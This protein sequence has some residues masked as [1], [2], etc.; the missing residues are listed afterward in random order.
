[1]R[2]K[3][4][5]YITVLGA[6]A[7]FF[8]A[9]AYTLSL[10]GSSIPPDLKTID[11]QFFENNA[12]LAVPTL[13]QQ[14]TEALKNRIRTQTRLSIVRG[15]ANA[16]MSGAI[17]GYSIAPVSVQ[18]TN[19]NVAPIAGASRLTI[20]VSVKYVY[21]ADKKLSFEESFTKYKDFTGDIASQE[22]GLIQDINRQL[23]DDIFN[24]AFAN[25]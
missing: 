16:T 12:Q 19:T 17:T 18:A 3:L 9:C 1:M 7:M 25:W 2:R 24:R 21:D 4:F 14:F 5:L 23:T 6:V 13:S 10:N 20:T 22:Q 8:S 15:E 11:I